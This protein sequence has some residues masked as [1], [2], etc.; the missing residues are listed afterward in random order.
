MEMPCWQ[1]VVERM[2]G[3]G[4]PDAPTPMQPQT[5]PSCHA[6]L[7]L[8]MTWSLSNVISFKLVWIQTTRLKTAFL[9]SYTKNI[10]WVITVLCHVTVL[11]LGTL[12]LLKKSILV[13]LRSLMCLVLQVEINM[14]L[15]VSVWC[16]V[17]FCSLGASVSVN[18]HSLKHTLP[19]FHWDL[20]FL[21]TT[22]QVRTEVGPH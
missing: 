15:N 2:V 1:T 19:Q 17:H 3:Q 7:C 8:Q 9:L 10:L 5:L 6:P 14:G 4:F 18:A 12:L 21:A 11:P 16:C 20:R 13:F 22:E